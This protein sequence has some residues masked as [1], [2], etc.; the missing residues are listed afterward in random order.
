MVRYRVRPEHVARNVEL[1]RAV[2][3]EVRSVRPQGL[4]YASFQLDDEVSFVEFVI[5]GGQGL[6]AGLEA[7][8]AY[9]STIEERLEAP[10]VLEELDEIGA[11]G[12]FA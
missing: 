1:L 8:R 5:G 9:R 7:F 3:D 12:L 11:Y 6:L 10:P 2:H 4:R